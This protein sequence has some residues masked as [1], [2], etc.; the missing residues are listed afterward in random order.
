MGHT[1]RVRRSLYSLMLSGKIAFVL[2]SEG[3]GMRRLV[4]EKCDEVV[5]IPIIGQT[6]S[7]NV[8]QT[9]AIVLAETLRQ[10]ME[11]KET[12]QFE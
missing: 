3:K 8:S 10:R 2:G 5:S 1:R 12:I 7:L 11:R 9:A 4:R 6:E